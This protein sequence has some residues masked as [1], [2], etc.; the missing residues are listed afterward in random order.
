MTAPYM[1]AHAADH[2]HEQDV[3]HDR[4]RQGGVGPVVAQPQRQQRAGDRRGE[5]RDHGGGGAVGDDPVAQRLGAELV[6]ADRLQH[7][8]ERRV[9]DAQQQ[10]EDGRARRRRRGNRRGCGR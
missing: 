10:Q 9:H 7:A 3:D 4:E 2:D 6:L 5:R 1:R 8:P